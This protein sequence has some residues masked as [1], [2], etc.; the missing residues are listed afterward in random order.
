MLENLDLQLFACSNNLICHVVSDKCLS[1]DKA[2]L[3]C[4]ACWPSNGLL[5]LLLGIWFYC[6]YRKPHKVSWFQPPTSVQS[7]V[8]AWNPLYFQHLRSFPKIVCIGL[9]NQMSW[10]N[11][12]GR[13]WKYSP[14][15][16]IATRKWTQ[17]AQTSC[18][19]P[20]YD[21]QTPVSLWAWS[22]CTQLF[23][24]QVSLDPTSHKLI[25]HSLFWQGLTSL[26][27]SGCECERLSFFS[28]P[29]DI[30]WP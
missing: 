15:W 25:N 2:H 12:S 26:L 6:I 23:I 27:L 17:S 24:M 5:S 18:S 19:G 14:Q 29:S 22:S 21:K 3:R 30:L 16:E 20:H 7:L 4:A 10:V 13:L 1:R 11:P 9:L 28:T 8:Y